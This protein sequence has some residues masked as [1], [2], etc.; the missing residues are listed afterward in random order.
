MKDK[1]GN[2][3]TIKYMQCECGRAMIKKVIK[4][5]TRIYFQQMNLSVNSNSESPK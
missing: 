4:S 5:M 2:M 1:D 3:K